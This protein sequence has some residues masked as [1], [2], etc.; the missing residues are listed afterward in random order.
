M[1]YKET[2]N[3]HMGFHRTTNGTIAYLRKTFGIEFLDEVLKRTAQ[4]VY[5]SIREDLMRGN[6]EQLVEH[7][8]YY[9][10]REGGQYTIEQIGDEIRMTVHRCP[11]HHYLKNRGIE[12]DL[13]FRRQTTVLNRA[14]AEGTPFEIHTEILDMGSYV[15]IIRGREA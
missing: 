9:L 5:R 11:A 6:P 1:R 10:N 15:Q 12:P 13:A 7:W 3:V 14:L 8:E 4:R 2:G